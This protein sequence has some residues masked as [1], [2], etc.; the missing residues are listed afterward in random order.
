[1]RLDFD[2]PLSAY[3]LPV[4]RRVSY[5]AVFQWLAAGWR[6]LRANPLPA[7]AYGL[8]FGIGGDLIILAALDR[9]HLVMVAISGFF[10]LAPFLA[11][12]LYELSRAHAAGERL[13]FIDSLRVF[14]RNVS[15][16]ALFGLLVALALVLWER[17]TAIAFNIFG[18]AGN[19]E[20]LAYLLDVLMRGEHLAYVATW[21]AMGAILALFVFAIAVVS[22]PLM[23][24]RQCDVATAIVTSLHV[25]ARNPGPLLLWAALIVLLV[26]LGFATLLF[27]MVLIMPLLGHASW[28]AY[29]DLV[30]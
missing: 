19:T 29:R 1:M 28:Q 20:G 17:F 7:I 25:F 9:P 22:V 2:T 23:V 30:E 10:L 8:L 13:M 12:G 15:Q 11:A 5:A 4:V 14:R 21:V 24:D 6:D 16:L 18:L 3:N 27:G 26:L